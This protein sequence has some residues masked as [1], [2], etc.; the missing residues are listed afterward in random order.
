MHQKLKNHQPKPHQS[1][2]IERITTKSY[3]DSRMKDSFEDH[4]RVLFAK[5]AS[6]SL[7]T[8]TNTTTASTGGIN[9]GNYNYVGTGSNNSNISPLSSRANFT[10]SASPISARS[11]VEYREAICSWPWSPNAQRS[12][13]KRARSNAISYEWVTDYQSPCL[14]WQTSRL[15][16]EAPSLSTTPQPHQSSPT[17]SPFPSIRLSQPLSLD[18]YSA[19]P[20]AF[21]PIAPANKRARWS[22]ASD[23]RVGSD[24]LSKDSRNSQTSPLVENF[25]RDWAQYVAFYAHADASTMRA[26]ELGRNNVYGHRRS[27]NTKRSRDSENNLVI[28]DCNYDRNND[29]D[30]A[31]ND[32]HYNYRSRW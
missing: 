5:A 3:Y 4:P 30:D 14:P 6:T 11:S 23:I 28:Y 27:A 15:L 31:H 20:S 13:H 24:N 10:S 25:S 7:S 18:P 22:P 32:Y 8:S 2:T 19:R 29:C 21:I 12:G 1:L 17:P 9:K 16:R 26:S